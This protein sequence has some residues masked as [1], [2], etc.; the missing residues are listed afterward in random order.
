MPIT[1]VHLDRPW[2]WGGQHRELAALDAAVAAVGREGIVAGDFNSAPWTFSTRRIAAAG[3]VALVSGAT[4]TWPTTAPLRLPL[5]QVYAGPCLA[6]S[7]VT[8]GP[9]LGSDHFPLIVD[10]NAEACRG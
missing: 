1:A 6:A 2:P 7:A 8:R 9:A 4:A 5:D 10:F 3:G